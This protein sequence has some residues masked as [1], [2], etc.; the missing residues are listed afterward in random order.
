MQSLVVIVTGG[1]YGIG[2]A[3]TL[4][5]AARRH[6]VV[7]FGVEARQISSIAE[8]AIPGLRE[9]LAQAALEADLMEADVTVAD[10]VER[11]VNFTLDKHGRIDAL[12]NNAAIG[13]L[14]TVLETT[15]AAWDRIM[16]VNLRGPFLCAKA[17]LPHMIAAGGGRIVN[18][19]SGAGW[20]KPN[21]AAYAASKGGLH[22]LSTALAYDHFRD[23]IRVNTVIPGGGGIV[24]G[25]SLGRVGGGDMTRLVV[26][27]PV[28]RQA[29]LPTA[30]ISPRWSPSSCPKMPTPSPAPLSTSAASRTRAVRSQLRVGGKPEQGTFTMSDVVAKPSPHRN[31]ALFQ[32]K[33]EVEDFLYREADLLD[34]R[35]FKEWLALLADDIVYFMP[36]RRNVKFGQHADRENTRQGEGISWFDED[37]WTLSKRVDQILTGV[38]YAEEPLSRVTHMVTNVH[39][40]DARPSAEHAA[41][42]TVTSRFLVY[43]NRVEYE[44]YT[45]VG[46][47][48]DTLRR[49]ENDWQI[50]RREI[51]LDQSILLAKNLTIFF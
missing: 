27:R 7:A 36:V 29:G 21:M 25:M 16:A 15:E 46:R 13:P 19:G 32:L 39:I 42:V 51:I 47:R 35:K 1:T 48:I 8:N 44:T 41:E 26:T 38:H 31:E 9:E 12:V 40:T 49:A 43:Q 22:A 23:R 34:N 24:S 45:Y 11:V 20:G 18:V 2:R 17:V 28:R 4:A 50:A 30:K 14:G 6:C 33:L 10:D 3:I 37:K 5:L